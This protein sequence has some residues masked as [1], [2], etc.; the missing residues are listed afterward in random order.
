MILVSQINPFYVTSLF[1][2]LR[3]H[4]KSE[5]F[6]RFQKRKLKEWTWNP[7]LILAVD[8]SFN[9]YLTCNIRIEINVVL[10]FHRANV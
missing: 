4:Q 10:V 9:G 5:V 8:I 2:Y 3:K 6:L 7:I 1:I